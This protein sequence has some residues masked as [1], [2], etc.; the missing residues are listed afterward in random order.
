MNCLW[1][2]IAVLF[3]L[4]IFVGLA[5]TGVYLYVRLNFIENVLRIFQ[6]R[7]LFVI[8]R[9]ETRIGAEDVEFESADGL[10]LHGCYLK[11]DQPR[12]GVILFGLE[13]GSNRWSCQ[14]YCE[15]LLQSGYDIFAF[16]P[17][18]QG[19]SEGMEGY[20]PLQW[21]TSHEYADTQ[22][23][24]NY[25]K[26][27]PDADPKGI[28]LFGISKGA[29]AGLMAASRNRYVRCIVTDGAFGTCSTMVPYMR[30][31]IALYNDNYLT[32][33]LLPYWFYALVAKA[34]I[35]K[36]ERARGVKFMHIEP[37][38]G[39]IKRPLLMIH[40]GG[41]TYIKVDMAKE[42]FRRAA[43]PKSFWVVPNAKH[44]QAINLAGE[45]YSNRVTCFFDLHLAG[46]E[47]ATVAAVD[48]GEFEPVNLSESAVVAPA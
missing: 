33:G 42:L 31:W 14:S 5:L 3:S 11:T 8:P 48:S 28:G 20:E 26:N 17:R 4:P 12:K 21:L 35:H 45:D 22:A 18:N 6:E 40:G 27:R 44:N 23:A 32:H 24:I 34:C 41:D 37:A 13:F 15:P 7:P 25:L 46:I 29:N 1:I 43:G 36:V 30:K 9:G 39:R 2:G 10:R 47:P 19:D 38:M 16:E